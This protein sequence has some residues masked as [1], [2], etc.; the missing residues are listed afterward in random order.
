MLGEFYNMREDYR[1]V[2]ITTSYIRKC[3]FFPRFIRN[4]LNDILW[5]QYRKKWKCLYD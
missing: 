5:S 1:N 2:L 4:L 3:K